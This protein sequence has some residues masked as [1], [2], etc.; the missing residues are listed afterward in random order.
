MTRRARRQ[1]LAL[2]A[3][4]KKAWSL[5]EAAA[6]IGCDLRA[7]REI[8]RLLGIRPVYVSRSGKRSK[9]ALSDGQLKRIYVRYCY[10]A[11]HGRSHFRIRR[12]GLGPAERLE[13]YWAAL[14]RQTEK[15]A[16]RAQALRPTKE[17]ESS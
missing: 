10:L 17:P 14:R 16:A 6:L 12:T 7:A 1:G 5:K 2:V 9:Y 8:V 13:A 4:Q 15:M 11:C 3:P